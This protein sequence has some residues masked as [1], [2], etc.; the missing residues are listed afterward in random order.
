MIRF[1]VLFNGFAD[2]DDR[3]G[4]QA[5]CDRSSLGAVRVCF[6]RRIVHIPAAPRR[7]GP[8]RR[9]PEA[10]VPMWNGEPFV[11]DGTEHA[12]PVAECVQVADAM[13]PGALETG[14]LRDG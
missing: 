2:R 11:Q 7:R 1:T 14:N 4:L 6:E 3:A 9:V 5:I 12:D 13:N 8:G 10:L